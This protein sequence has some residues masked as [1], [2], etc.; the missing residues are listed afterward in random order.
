MDSDSL[1]DLE[2]ERDKINWINY[3]ISFLMGCGIIAA[4]TFVFINNVNK[5]G[6]L[7]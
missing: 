1:D 2:P 3:L 6:K 7:K 5:V 4:V